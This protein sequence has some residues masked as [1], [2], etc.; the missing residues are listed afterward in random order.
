MASHTLNEKFIHE[1]R[2][3]LDA[4]HQFTDPLARRATPLVQGRRPPRRRLDARHDHGSERG[5]PNR[6]GARNVKRD[7]RRD[8]P[9]AANQI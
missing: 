3:I 6:P 5:D 1:L 7:D 2:D 8:I 9:S 4:E